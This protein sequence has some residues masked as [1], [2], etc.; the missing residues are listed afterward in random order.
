M[1]LGAVIALV[2][3][4]AG[5]SIPEYEYKRRT[6]ATEPGTLLLPCSFL[7]RNLKGYGKSNMTAPMSRKQ[8]T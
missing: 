4:G 2:I 1:S 6:K 7:N 8:M 5:A 3:G